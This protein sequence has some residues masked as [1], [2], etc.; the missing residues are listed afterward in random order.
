MEDHMKY[1]LLAAA[2]TLSCYLP[3]TV[4]CFGAEQGT[5]G[6]T[7]ADD[8]LKEISQ[9]EAKKII[10]AMVN[11]VGITMESLIN[12]MNRMGAGK[13]PKQMTPESIE[14]LRKKALDTL[15]FQELAYQRA[16]ALGL[17]PDQEKINDALEKLKAKFGSEELYEK[18]LKREGLTEE[19]MKLQIARSLSIESVYAQEVV[20]KSTVSEDELK[21]DYERQKK[22]FITPE[23]LVIDDVVF[24]LNTDDPES[25]KKAEEVLAKINQDKDK[26][27]SNLE[28]DGTFI[29]RDYEIKKDSDP[30]LYEA[31]K[32]LHEGELS[33][34]IQTADSFHIIRLKEY[35]PEKQA[36]FE[37]A[38]GYLE[39]KLK[40][41]AEQKRL[42]EWKK[43]LEKG[44][45]IEM[46]EASGGSIK[47][48]KDVKVPAPVR[49]E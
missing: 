1:V 14:A 43:E 38:R 4:Q 25:K 10:A 31:A 20:E 19:T 47:T 46:L 26:N 22:E 48:D 2:L 11:G 5:H 8:H 18:F 16:Q 17:S 13:D 28:P 21:K 9:E 30:K 33:G 36:S 44:A 40:T 49:T 3:V 41:K 12:M 32:K 23:K 27:P 39:R 6:A 15:I 35:K 34:V 24:F 7:Q 45:K 29:V 37:E 42:Q